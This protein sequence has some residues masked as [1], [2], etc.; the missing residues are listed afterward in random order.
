MN[1]SHSKLKLLNGNHFFYFFHSDLDLDPSD[2]KCNPMRGL[3][4]RFNP[5]KFHDEMSN[6]T[7]IIERKP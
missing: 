6:L 1:I 4:T 7:E 2:P 5:A 3:D